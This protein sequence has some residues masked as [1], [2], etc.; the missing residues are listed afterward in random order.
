M[1]YYLDSGS[2][3]GFLKIREQQKEMLQ[4]EAVLWSQLKN[5]PYDITDL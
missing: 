2:D 1:T 3:E 5:L 4:R